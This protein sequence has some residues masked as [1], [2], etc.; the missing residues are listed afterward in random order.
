M[1]HDS[2]MF[3]LWCVC[4]TVRALS[5]YLTIR[6]PNDGGMFCLGC[7]PEAEGASAVECLKIEVCFVSGVFA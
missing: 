2:C 6:V 3:C 5:W 7:L 4:M 1:S